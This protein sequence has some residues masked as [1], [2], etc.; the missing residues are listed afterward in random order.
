[1]KKEKCRLQNNKFLPKAAA[2]SFF[3][4]HSSFCLS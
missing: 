1:M 4:L 2:F 3:I